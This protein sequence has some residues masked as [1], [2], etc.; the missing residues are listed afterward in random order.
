MKKYAE[1]QSGFMVN[2]DI[3]AI[4]DGT[5]LQ[6]INLTLNNLE[7]FEEVFTKF[8]QCLLHSQDPIL[9]I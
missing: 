1:L 5:F 2:S 4:R 8:L 9:R 6:T 3:N 7:I